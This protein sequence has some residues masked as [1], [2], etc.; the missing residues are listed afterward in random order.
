MTQWSILLVAAL[1]AGCAQIKERVVLLPGADG[2]TGALAVS[3]A[4]GEAILAS[5]YATV[6]VRDGKVVQTTSSAEEVRG[7]YGKLLDAQPPRPRSFVLYFH[8]DR[9]D[10]TE[11]SERMLERMKNELAAAPSAE[12]VIIGHTDTMGSDSTNERLS[13][14]RAEIVRAALISIGIAPSAISIAGRGERELAVSTAD[15]V[16]EPKNRRAEIKVR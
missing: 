12:V 1:L 11:D 9:I 14:K 2:R 5:P 13:L 8:F 15:E 10:L 3:T 16:P 7:R 4:K 6:E